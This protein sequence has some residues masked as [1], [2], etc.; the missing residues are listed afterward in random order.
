VQVQQVSRF[1]HSRSLLSHQPYPAA[2][3]LKNKVRSTLLYFVP[4]MLTVSN[5]TNWTIGQLVEWIPGT[6]FLPAGRCLWRFHFCTLPQA[7]FLSRKYRIPQKGCASSSGARSSRP[8][9]TFVPREQRCLSHVNTQGTWWWSWTSIEMN[10]IMRSKIP[11]SKIFLTFFLSQILLGIDRMTFLR[12]RFA[13]LPFIQ[14][15]L[16]M[17]CM[18]S[19]SN[20][21]C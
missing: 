6:D 12:S 13:E 5:P 7:E 11:F 3:G 4:R 17:L 21:L 1:E 9:P 18:N 10:L 14:I 19:K 8:L 2:S 20:P 15:T 16:P